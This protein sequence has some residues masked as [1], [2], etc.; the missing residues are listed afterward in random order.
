MDEMISRRSLLRA[1]GVVTGGVLLGGGLAGPARAAVSSTVEFDLSVASTQLI[2]E[3][4]LTDG[5]VL[6]SFGIDNVNSRIYWAQ[7]TSPAG[8]GDITITKT[9]LKGNLVGP[10]YVHLNGFGHGTQIG[11]QPDG[12][13]AYV[14]VEAEANADS[15]YGE[16]IARFRFNDF[17]EGQTLSS[18]TSGVEIFDPRPDGTSKSISIDPYWS[19]AAI[20]Y[21]Q[22]GLIY[23]RLYLLSDFIA[24]DYS[25]VLSE[26]VIDDFDSTF[27]GFTTF[28]SYFYVLTGNAYADSYGDPLDGKLAD[29]SY[30]DGNVYL[31]AVD[32]N[33][34][35]VVT[36]SLTKA[37]YTLYYREPEGMAVQLTDPS[38]TATARLCFGFASGD[39]GNRK[40]SIY[41][42]QGFK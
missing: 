38:D 39:S 18:G 16:K 42:K 22:D 3:A 10:N 29:G 41:Y 11:V 7:L 21:H 23:H 13:G 37:G 28:G 32:W 25:N 12:G 17:T 15:G 26:V 33:T 30:V 19:R 14:W 5:T 6:Q 31:R 35:S 4:A 24:H 8:N 1:G 20:R 9:D 36:T 27:Q 34:G 40:A 2:R